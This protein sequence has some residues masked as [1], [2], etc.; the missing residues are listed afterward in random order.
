MVEAQ[1]G[2]VDD[3][4]LEGLEAR[5]CGAGDQRQG[6]RHYHRQRQ[7]ETGLHLGAPADVV[8]QWVSKLKLLSRRPLFRSMAER[9]L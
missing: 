5:A 3:D 2:H 4:D 9:R 8:G 1:C 7:P 6:Q